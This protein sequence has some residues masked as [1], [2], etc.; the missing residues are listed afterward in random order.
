MVMVANKRTKSQMN[1]DLQLFLASQ[2]STFVDW[3]HIVLKKLK[4]VHV[5]NPNV[6]KK[7]TKRKNE[8]FI[9]VKTVK[10]EKK[11]S[12]IKKPKKKDHS[13]E[14]MK[15][16]TDNLP[17]NI[18]KLSE[19]RKIVLVQDN[20]NINSAQNDLG[21][22]IPSLAEVNS[23]SEKELRLI[24]KQ[25]KNVKSR[26]GMVVQSDSED[27]FLN[28][29]AEP[30]ELFPNEQSLQKKE[31]SENKLDLMRK[32]SILD[33]D[34]TT[35]MTVSSTEESQRKSPS[36]KPREHTRIIFDLNDKTRKKSVLER[37]GKRQ[38]DSNEE[39]ADYRTV[40]KK[41]KLCSIENKRE[42][43][44]ITTIKRKIFGDKQ[45]TAHSRIGDKKKYDWNKNEREQADAV[46]LEK[47]ENILSRLGVMSKV[48]IVPPKKPVESDEEDIPPKEVPSVVKVKPRVIPVNTPQANKNL[49]LKAV[50]E[51]QRSIAQTPSVGTNAKPDALFTKKYQQKIQERNSKPKLPDKEKNK[52][53][54]IMKNIERELNS[55]DEDNSLEY[56]PKPTKRIDYKTPDYIPS[57]KELLNS[58][59]TTDE[60]KAI[61]HSF[62]VT[63]DGI[64]KTQFES[65]LS[66]K[67]L[68]NKKRTPSPII[69]DKITTTIK[70][71]VNVPDRLPLVRTSPLVKNKERCKYWPSCRHGEKCEFVH[72]STNCKAFPQCKFGDKCLYIHP[73]C[74]F[75]SSCTRRDCPYSH[76]ILSKSVAS[77]IV[78]SSGIISIA[79]QA[80]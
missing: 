60:E 13:P 20:T 37:L 33:V 27:E 70:K 26:L 5:T 69:F 55:N 50:A 66:P 40:E 46:E 49:L 80:L 11:D 32:V 74:K 25:L 78:P 68:E 77:R 67:I 59:E 75:E 36:P 23:S 34:S 76:A 4:E 48:A 17:L 19:P 63:L 44:K 62:I 39:D 56:I 8:E 1:E 24:E 71:V 22:D 16:L 51:A 72:P 10:K 3:L 18:N 28:I 42:Q 15:S 7:T 53:K 35:S 12:K 2:T 58:L 54:N 57:P 73:S 61:N 45:N 47:R 79:K 64:D 38:A 43:L 6:F 9:D 31:R 21:F 41:S 52:L 30:D 65:K 14:P 29:K